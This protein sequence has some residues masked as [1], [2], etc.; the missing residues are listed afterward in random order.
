M[1]AL[2]P[3][4][5]S[6]HTLVF[7]QSAQWIWPHDCAAPNS[8]VLFRRDFNLE[9]D[10]ELRLDIAVETYAQVYLDGNLVHRC[11]SISYPK[12][13][14]FEHL[15][16][17]AVR[18]GDHQLAIVVFYVG[19]PSG[20]TWG[21]D[22]GLLCEVRNHNDVLI[23]ASDKT[24]K[25]L[26]LDAWK[27]QTRRAAF[28]NLDFIEHLDY[29]DLPNGYPCVD[30][31][32]CTDALA[33]NPY[34]GCRWPIVEQ[35]RYPFLQCSENRAFTLIHAG[36][37]DESA[38][39]NPA[40]AITLEG[41][42]RESAA[43]PET[44][45]DYKIPALN[46]DQAFTLFLE[47]DDY[48]TGYPCLDVIAEAGTIV[49]IA[50]HEYAEN[51]QFDFISAKLHAAD[52]FVLAEGLNRVQPEE[53]KAMRYVQITVRHLN[54]E[55]ILKDF[56]IEQSVYPL[57][58]GINI[59]CEHKALQKI[60]DLS[61]N[62]VKLCM[63]GIIMDCPWREKR[64]WI[65][66]VQRIALINHHSFQDQALVRGVL[67]Q[68]AY[69]Q[70]NNGQM[71]PCQPLSEE[72]P[73]Q[74]MEWLRAVIE[75]HQAT[76]DTSLLQ[77]LQQTIWR[78][79]AWFAEGMN[80]D[81]FYQPRG[82]QTV[83]WMENTFAEI[84]TFAKQSPAAFLNLRYLQCLEDLRWVAAYF[85]DADRAR[86]FAEQAKVLRAKIIAHF[87]DS[88]LG[89]LCEINAADIP[90]RYSEFSHAL[91]IVLGLDG[92]DAETLWSRY[93]RQLANEPSSCVAAS[94]FGKYHTHQALGLMG[95]SE[96]LLAD[97]LKYWGP[98]VAASSKTT[99]EV[100]STGGHQSLSQHSQC[101]GWA[102]IPVIALLRHVL[103]V[104]ILSPDALA[105]REHTVATSLGTISYTY[106]D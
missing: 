8:H 35:R 59:H 9:Q 68:H 31:D 56:F 12:Q 5:E 97:I 23:T 95:H 17:E 47:L 43:A 81:G 15:V 72:Y 67:R 45:S 96:E 93:Q 16:L 73:S 60:I 71:W 58:S 79:A 22:P 49:D 69:L 25:C 61:L 92:I 2:Q 27:G 57:A 89:L 66:D 52:R 13:H 11:N 91:A 7:P 98:M 19:V 40:H 87:Y 29:R 100:F 77:E 21:K 41:K 32:L 46:P 36:V 39:A 38:H 53:W 105:A 33:C 1:S 48:I 50:W 80:D 102:G 28:L 42:P 82:L 18:S 83:Q 55:C 4:S 37:V 3:E 20:S 70:E 99:W 65:G 90:L 54:T 78:M 34:P 104:D 24:W 51:Y 106:T 88:D 6:E 63:H 94:P 75:Y 85:D 76:G 86:A 103:G 62:A 101:H 30:L 44:M 84:R 14:Y 74:T 10:T 64:Q 26:Y